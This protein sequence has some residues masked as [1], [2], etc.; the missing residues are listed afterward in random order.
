MVT[1]LQYKLYF[2]LN[3][4]EITLKIKVFTIYELE[5]K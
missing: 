2:S 5:V 1:Y 3:V 4:I